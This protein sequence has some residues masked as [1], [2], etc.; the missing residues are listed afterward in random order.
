M[1]VSVLGAG[2]IGSMIGGLLKKHAPDI[3]VLLI[4]RGGHGRVVGER[5]AVLLIGPWGRHSVPIR[6]TTNVAEIAGSDIVLLTVKSQATEEAARTAQTHWQDATVVSIQN[7][8]ND[9]VL[10]P[11]VAPDKL[12][13]GMTATN[14]ALLEPGEVS[15]QLDG[16][17]VLGPPAG[18]S[19]GPHVTRAADVLGRINVRGLRFLAHPNAL[20]MR[21]NKLTINALGYASC[22]S[23]SNFVT[24]ALADCGWRQTVGRPIVQE[25]RRVFDRAGIQLEP[26]PDRSNLP[27]L[28][29]LMRLLDVPLVGGVIR[30][31]AGQ[32]F[33]RR[34]IVFSLYQDLLKSKPTEVD[35]INGEIVRLA[36][37]AGTTAPINAEVCRM[38]HELEARGDRSFFTRAQVVERLGSVDGAS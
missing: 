30:T 3:D 31:G 10:A 24:E 21:Y 36:E 28:E 25:C 15:L 27:K 32:I 12:V 1:K 37:S 22:L 35:Y 14:M 38:V 11:L 23:A 16:L 2:A 20:G 18:D 7:G 9:H 29:R 33:N 6:S 13:M 34:P 17:T 19:M 4:M 26:V 5:G 8:I